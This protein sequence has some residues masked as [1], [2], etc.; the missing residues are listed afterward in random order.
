MY[1]VEL[2]FPLPPGPA[3]DAVLAKLAD[4]GAA[5]GEPVTQADTYYAHPV[6]DFAATDEA[7]RVRVVT[8]PDGVPRG[9]LTYKGP[10][11]DAATKTR[12]EF[13][14]AFADGPEPIAALRSALD[15]LGFG[16]VF[17]VT[18]TRRAAALTTPDAAGSPRA[19]EVTRDAVENVGE[20]MEI[21][22]V[23][24]ADSLDAARA[25]VLAFAADLGLGGAIRRSYLG[26]ALEAAGRPTGGG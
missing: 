6:R 22:T 4:R 2:K 24:D 23:A 11:L 8:G 13:E 26:M 14:P 5:F 21:E 18:K 19:Y 16:E 10:K 20:F 7:L 12:E 1:E 3:A 25:G 15:R 17:T 9:R